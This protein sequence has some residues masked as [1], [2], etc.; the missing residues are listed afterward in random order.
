[1]PDVELEVTLIFIK[2][3]SHYAMMGF[4]AGMRNNTVSFFE[5]SFRLLS[6]RGRARGRDWRSQ[7]PPK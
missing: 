7:A 2:N 6:L 1:M 5:F 3:T 4:V